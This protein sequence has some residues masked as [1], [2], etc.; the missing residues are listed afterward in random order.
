MAF[1][2][3]LIKFVDGATY[4]VPMPPERIDEAGGAVWELVGCSEQRKA[5]THERL[6]S[7]VFSDMERVIRQF[8]DAVRTQ[9]QHAELGRPIHPRRFGASEL[10]C[11]TVPK[12]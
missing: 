12:P 4:S 11:S 1:L 7:G 5:L 10:L 9:S 6:L 8:I 3:E 2:H